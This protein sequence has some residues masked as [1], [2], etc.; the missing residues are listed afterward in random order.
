M[1]LLVDIKKEYNETMS[2]VTDVY[3]RIETLQIFPKQHA[4][5]ANITGFVS[6]E[7]GYIMKESNIADVKNME[8][9]FFTNEILNGELMNILGRDNVIPPQTFQEPH[10]IFRDYYTIWLLDADGNVKPEYKDIK[11]HDTEAIYGMF[12]NKIKSF[13]HRFENVRDVLIDPEIQ[14]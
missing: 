5:R 9:F 13:E 6:A 7:S 11:I 14:K 2:D 3:I 12:Y 4:V 10:P 1:G 8:E